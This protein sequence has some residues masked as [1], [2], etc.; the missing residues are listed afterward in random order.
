MD[1]KFET[2]LV[3]KHPK[4]IHFFRYSGIISDNFLRFVESN[5]KH[6]HLSESIF[7]INGKPN[8]IAFDSLNIIFVN[9]LELNEHEYINFSCGYVDTIIAHFLDVRTM[10]RIN[11]ECYKKIVWRTWGND[12][13]K[14]LSYLPTLKLKLKAIAERCLWAFSLRRIANQFKGIGISSSECDLIELRRRRI[15][16]KTFV[17][18][19]PKSSEDIEIKSSNK[20]KNELNDLV[21]M[22][23]HSSNSS[24]R[25]LK[26][27]KFFNK[28][29][30]Q[31][32]KLFIPLAYGR[33]NYRDKILSYLNKKSILKSIV[34]TNQISFSEYVKLLDSVDCC[35][36]DIKNQMALGNIN[37]LMLLGKTVFLNEKGIVYKTFKNQNLDVYTVKRLKNMK[38]DDLLTLCKE[39]SSKNVKY[40]ESI[41]SKSF[42][43]KKW[44]EL[45]YE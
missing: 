44:D 20:E 42:I 11:K 39:Y 26:W 4:Y 7:V 30:D 38:F 24:L 2:E 34:I 43:I 9:D 21:V 12:L 27:I 6:F 13:Y 25:H 41:A 3:R 37:T 29:N 33:T 10:K 5:P 28:L 14:P 45:F 31:K 17:L 19:Y 16:T 36:F 23:G 8:N 1:K 15:R 22:I 40:A 35:V 32:I 18:P